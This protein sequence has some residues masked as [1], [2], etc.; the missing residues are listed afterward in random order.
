MP[1]Q[2]QQPGR[3]H[4]RMPMEPEVCHQ[5]PHRNP[6]RTISRQA[7]QDRQQSTST[8]RSID[9]GASWQHLPPTTSMILAPVIWR[10]SPRAISRATPAASSAGAT[11]LR[12]SWP[13]A[14]PCVQLDHCQRPVRPHSAFFHEQFL[15][16]SHVCTLTASGKRR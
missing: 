3:G 6:V 4:R 9:S 11:L 16:Q 12:Y 7:V 14:F 5:H 15:R 13:N 10:M 8:K 1:M 2:P